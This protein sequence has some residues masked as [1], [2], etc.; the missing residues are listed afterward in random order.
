MHE[1]EQDFEGVEFSTPAGSFPAGRHSG[2]SEAQDE[3]YRR[4]RRRVRRRMAFYRHVSTFVTVILVLF[5]IDIAT[6]DG[7]WVQWVALIWGAI[8]LV[9][10]LNI[11]AFDSLLG[12]EAEQRML[13][14]EIRRQRGDQ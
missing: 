8:L 6:G 12:R 7:F 3:E 11:F 2:G 13:E 10:F 9:H 5:I 14:R 1:D 4:A